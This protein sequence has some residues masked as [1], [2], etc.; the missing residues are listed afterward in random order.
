MSSNLGLPAPRSFPSHTVQGTSATRWEQP[1]ANSTGQHGERKH[2]DKMRRL[3]VESQT[4][5]AEAL[6]HLLVLI[7]SFV[8]YVAWLQQ[9]PL[10][11]EGGG[12]RRPPQGRHFQLASSEMQLVQQRPLQLRENLYTHRR[13]RHGRLVKDQIAV[14]LHI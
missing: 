2:R 13:S 7:V 3:G 6:G 11:Q 8:P 4:G 5:Q 9:D 1:R 10:T 12:R 14:L